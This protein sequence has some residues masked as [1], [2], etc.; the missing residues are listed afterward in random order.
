VVS[1]D[2]AVTGNTSSAS[3]PLALD[4]LREAGALPPAAAAL[5]A[6][7]GAGLDVAGQVVTLP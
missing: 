1:R 2:V 7:F 3:V 6:G 4:A 5:L